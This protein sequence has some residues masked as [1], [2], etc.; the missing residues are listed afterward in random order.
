M[1]VCKSYDFWNYN[2]NY[3]DINED[4]HQNELIIISLQNCFDKNFKRLCYNFET[5]TSFNKQTF[6]Y[7]NIDKRMKSWTVK[8]L[9]F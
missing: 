4:A 6:S 9:D 5:F 1:F 3:C 2:R 7:T 8:F